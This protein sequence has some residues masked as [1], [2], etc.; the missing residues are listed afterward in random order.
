MKYEAVLEAPLAG[1]AQ[2]VEQVVVDVV[3]LELLHRVVVHFYARLEVRKVEVRHL[4]GD[5]VFF[6]RVSFQGDACRG[7]RPALHIYGCRIEVI[8]SV[9]DGVVYQA[10]HLFLV[11]D[12]SAFLRCGERRPAHTSV[13]QNGDLVF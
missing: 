7:F 4:G 8:H 11:D 9:F 3:R 13:A 6:S 12:V 1:V 2:R 5:E 10:V